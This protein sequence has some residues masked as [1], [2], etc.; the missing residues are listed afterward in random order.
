MGNALK[1]ASLSGIQFD[2]IIT[3]ET[4]YSA[5]VPEYP[6]EDGFVVSDAILNKPVELSVTAFITDTP[7]TWKNQ[8]GASQGKYR[9][10]IEQLENLYFSKSI[11]SFATSD[12]VYDS[13]AITSLSIPETEEMKNAV[14]VSFSLKEIRITSADSASIPASNGMS[15]ASGAGGGTADTATDS[16]S[17]ERNCSVLYGL[18]VGADTPKTGAKSTGTG[19]FVRK[20]S[21]TSARAGVGTSPMLQQGAAK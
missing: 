21:V 7:V 17:S 6:V 13:M 18:L 1:P 8:L 3:R 20:S 14:Q 12:K 19:L 4:S 2:A 11:V 10:T 15:G 9:K 5:D 16:S